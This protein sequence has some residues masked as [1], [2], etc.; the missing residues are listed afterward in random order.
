M[1]TVQVEEDFLN[2]T[3]KVSVDGK[4]LKDKDGNDR[5]FKST[6][7]AAIEGAREIDRRAVNGTPPHD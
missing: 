7:E 4:I 1:N 6:F 5:T 2:N 3:I